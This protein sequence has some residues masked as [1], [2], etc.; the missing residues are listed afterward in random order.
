MNPPDC[1]RSG[2]LEPLIARYALPVP[3]AASLATLL[4]RLASDE[5][6]PTSA[7]AA[8]EA[9]DRH[10]AD[11]L[12]GLEL[13]EVREARSGAD[14]GSGAGLPG[15]VLAAALPR[16]EMRLVEAQ[17]SKCAYI[18]GLV[19][20]MGVTNAR[21]VCA[22]VEEWRDGIGANDLVTARALGPQPLVLE[23]SAPILALRGRLV[24]WRGA[25]DADEEARAAAAACELGLRPVE[26]KAVE[27][28]AGARARHLHVFEKVAPTPERFPRRAGVAARRPLGA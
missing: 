20:A 15:L 28:F 2:A 10:I 26:V 24:E 27:P 13:A 17:Q 7:S 14:L 5:R 18:A 9:L 8:H 3:A 22:R 19:A 23:Y 21:V 4:A 25:R 6:A 12:V 1:D 11:S 16:L